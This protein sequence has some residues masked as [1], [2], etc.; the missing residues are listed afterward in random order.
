MFN[1]P[2]ACSR[3][4]TAVQCHWAS[5]C[6]CRLDMHGKVERNHIPTTPCVYPSRLTSY[7]FFFEERRLSDYLQKYWDTN[8]IFFEEF[9]SL[10]HRLSSVWMPKSTGRSRVYCVC[11]HWYGKDLRARVVSTLRSMQHGR[12]LE[13]DRAYLMSSSWYIWFKNTYKFMFTILIFRK[14][15]I[16]KLEI[17]CLKL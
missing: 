2:W 16:S 13:N 3:G 1:L 11:I 10:M 15:Y 14:L 4:W 5:C 12:K 9:D 17:F 6:Q 7:F 8:N